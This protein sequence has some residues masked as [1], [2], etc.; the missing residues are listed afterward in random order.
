M[1][2]AS[3]VDAVKEDSME[4]QKQMIAA[5]FH[6]LAQAPQQG[7]KVVSTFVPGNINELLMCFDM[8]ETFPKSMP[9]RTACVRRQAG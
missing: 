8:A 9:C 6:E 4:K 2:Q 3:P 1:S 7:G 5:N